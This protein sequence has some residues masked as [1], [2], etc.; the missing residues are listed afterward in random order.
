MCSSFFWHWPCY[1]LSCP[2]F[3]SA[4]VPQPVPFFLCPERCNRRVRY[5][6]ITSNPRLNDGLPRGR[7]RKFIIDIKGYRC[8]EVSLGHI[9]LRPFCV[10]Q[11]TQFSNCLLLEVLL[12]RVRFLRVGREDSSIGCLNRRRSRSDNLGFI[13]RLRLHPSS[14]HFKDFSF[15]FFFREEGGSGRGQHSIW[16]RL[17]SILFAFSFLSP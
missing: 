9:F 5:T 1:S 2:V 6:A 11:G 10:L 16:K 3:H 15:F 12:L 7:S 8:Y 4:R 17:T 14:I 13:D